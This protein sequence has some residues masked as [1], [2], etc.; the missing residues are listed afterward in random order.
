MNYYQRTDSGRERIGT[1]KPPIDSVSRVLYHTGH[2][3]LK[4]S[5]PVF[6]ERLGPRSTESVYLLCAFICRPLSVFNSDRMGAHMKAFLFIIL[7]GLSA[8]KLHLEEII[9]T[10]VKWTE[11]V[12]S[13]FHLLCLRP[14]ASSFSPA[15]WLLMCG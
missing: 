14:G 6:K 10:A 8:Q 9:G 3:S 15:A 2:N 5:A 12:V 4:H 11:F 1:L 7:N 13:F